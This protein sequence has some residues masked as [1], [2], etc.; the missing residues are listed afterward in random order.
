MQGERKM[1]ERELYEL[2]LNDENFRLQREFA[3]IPLKRLKNL[4]SLYALVR[5]C[6]PKT[7]LA[8]SLKKPLE[9]AKRV[10]L[11]RKREGSDDRKD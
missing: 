1:T 6:Y 7:P 9:V 8:E 3:K 2:V 4:I 11:E 5:V 10:F